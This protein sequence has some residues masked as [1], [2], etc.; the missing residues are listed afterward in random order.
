MMFIIFI[1]TLKYQHILI[2]NSEIKDVR[3]KHVF[4]KKRVNM[5]VN[6]ICTLVGL[7]LQ[8]TIDRF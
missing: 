3:Y 6:Y 7:Q 4:T 8:Y 1:Y 2:F 5:F